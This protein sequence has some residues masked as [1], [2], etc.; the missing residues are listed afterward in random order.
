MTPEQAK[1]LREPFPKEQIGK[2][3]KAGLKLDYVGH[4][5]VCDR[6]LK[7]DPDWTW[8]PMAYTPEGLPLVTKTGNT[9]DLW[10]KLTVC[11]VTRPGV[12]TC[13]PNAIDLPKQL[14]SDALRNAA[15]RFGVAL[16]LWSK[17][18]LLHAEA[19][20]TAPTPPKGRQPAPMVQPEAH[21]EADTGGYETR[22]QWVKEVGLLSRDIKTAKRTHEFPPA[23]YPYP[24]R[25]ETIA[26]IRQV[27][28][29]PKPKYD[30]SNFSD[31][32]F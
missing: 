14:I 18:D 27:L 30:P 4:A 7:V 10:I 21:D 25:A 24:W 11:G 13:A 2:L 20:Q 16:D 19:E 22:E 28:A 1:A 3:P 31:E 32:A 15:M 9:A 23:Q 17:E 29:T 26:E 6:L 12:G 5:S 8:E